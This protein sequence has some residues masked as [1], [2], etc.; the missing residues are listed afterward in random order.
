MYDSVHN[1]NEYNVSHFNK[2]S[3][4]DSKF[5]IINKFYKDFKKLERL[6]SQNKET[7]QSK[8][9]VLKMHRCFIMSGL[10][11]IKKNI[12][13]VLKAKIKTGGKNMIIKI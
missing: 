9:T 13:S 2:I 7:K 8:I 5:D 6:G 3:S 10:I 11:C 4:I 12:V 1:F